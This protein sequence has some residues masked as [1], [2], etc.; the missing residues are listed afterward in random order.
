MSIRGPLHNI[1]DLT[2][3]EVDALMHGGGARYA[4]AHLTN[5]E[6]ISALLATVAMQR[7][8][9]VDALLAAMD[10]TASEWSE[11]EDAMEDGMEFY[12]DEDVLVLRG[13]EPVDYAGMDMTV[14]EAEDEEEAEM[15]RA[16]AN[17]LALTQEFWARRAEED[18]R[19]RALA[20]EEAWLVHMEH[21]ASD[22][23]GEEDL[24]YVRDDLNLRF[25]VEGFRHPVT[26]YNASEQR[27]LS[28]MN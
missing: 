13:V 22:N 12:D 2:D 24:C 23:E 7:E 10:D 20:Y 8:Q 26:S 1:I 15:M 3:M 19:A 9:E 27:L 18:A 6:Q 14:E 17:E 28:A 21:D 4:N 11:C 25:A 5:E 16:E